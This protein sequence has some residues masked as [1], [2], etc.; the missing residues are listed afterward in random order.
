MVFTRVVFH[1]MFCR[2]H[3]TSDST[4]GLMQKL[5]IALFPNSRELLQWSL[6][7]T[8][9][10][11]PDEAVTVFCSR[12][13]GMVK[14]DLQRLSQTVSVP[15]KAATPVKSFGQDSASFTYQV[16]R[17]I[18]VLL[19]RRMKELGHSILFLNYS[20]IV[21]F[22]LIIVNAGKQ[23]IVL[24]LFKFLLLICSIFNRIILPYLVKFSTLLCKFIKLQKNFWPCGAYKLKFW[25][26]WSIDCFP[27]LLSM[28]IS[29][30][31]VNKKYVT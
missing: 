22:I 27:C 9:I 21:C 15:V 26:W 31:N 6:V 5:P 24:F 29:K 14:W 25:Q 17:H 19:Q 3:T 11:L 1:E 30:K 4:N 8:C 23:S 12:W 20:F 10:G 13:N 16:P 2:Q 7:S 28:M 18:P